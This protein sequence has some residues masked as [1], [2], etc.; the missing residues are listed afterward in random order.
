M[1]RDAHWQLIPAEQLV[2][3]DLIHLRLGD[4]G[5]AD[6]R[7]F[8][9]VVEADESELTGESLPVEKSAGATAYAGSRINSLTHL[10][11]KTPS[12]QRD[13]PFWTFP[14]FNAQPIFH[15]IAEN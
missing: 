13:V 10:G 14:R 1:L 5:P 2:S 12:G 7:L 6:V 9:G 3:G 8:D 11:T 4:L 15:A